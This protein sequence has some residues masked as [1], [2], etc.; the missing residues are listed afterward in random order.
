MAEGSSANLPMLGGTKDPAR[1]TRQEAK[2]R[3]AV[4]KYY[5]MGS[6]GEWTVEEIADALEVTPRQVYRYLND[7]DLAN[8]VREVLAVTDAEWRLDMALTL[9]REVQRLEEIEKELLTRKKRVP[10]GY[11]DITV[12]GTPTGEHNVRLAEEP[13]TY[14][15]KIPTPTNFETVTDYGPDLERVQKEKRQYLAQIAKLLG[16]NAADKREIDETLTQRHEEVKIVEVRQTDDPYPEA[17]VVDMREA[18]TDAADGDTKAFE[19]DDDP[20]GDE[21]DE[22]P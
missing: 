9:R 19:V 15:L 13:S 1:Y 14:K 3:F 5:G 6:D 2:V 11:E 12:R 7:S 8:E 20:T 10:T 17:D 16:L 4:A 22:T 18:S 21:E